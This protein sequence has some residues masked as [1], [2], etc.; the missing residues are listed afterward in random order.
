MFYLTTHSTHFIYGYMASAEYM[1]E[2]MNV[3]DSVRE[4]MNEWMFNDAPARKTDRPLGVRQ[5][6]NNTVLE[7][8]GWVAN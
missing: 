6:V 1:N 8:Y 3:H 7:V 4:W 5:M 2:W